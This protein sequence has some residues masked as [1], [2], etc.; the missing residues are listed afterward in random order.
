MGEVKEKTNG[1]LDAFGKVI[2]TISITMSRASSLLLI[3][4]AILVIAD[5]I[6]RWV[7]HSSLYITDIV[8]YMLVC[9]VF[10]SIADGLRGKHHIAADVLTSRMNKR[11]K[12]L[13][14]GLGLL[15]TFI[16]TCIWGYYFTFFVGSSYSSGE[17]TSNFIRA[18]F[19]PAKAI[20]AL[21]V[22][23]FGLMALKN[24]LV[25]MRYVIQN[26]DGV[27]F[28]KGLNNPGIVIPVYV[29]LWVLSVVLMKT[30]S[31][32]AGVVVLLL[33]L[34]CSGAS[35]AISIM[36]TGM[37]VL[38]LL[39][40]TT[41]ANLLANVPS[42][43]FSYV[44][45]YSLLALPMFIFAGAVMAE[46]GLGDAIFNFANV[47]VR[48]IRGGLGI[49][50]VIAC[51]I[52]G[53]L[54]GSSSACCMTIGAVG[55]PALVKNGYD[56]GT[57]A[58]LIAVA[59]GIGIMI[60]P[61]NPLIVYGTLTDSSI[62]KLFMAGIGPGI[63]LTVMLSI[64]LIFMCRKGQTQVME[65]ASLREKAS[66]TKKSF[67]A[68]LLPVIILG[69]IYG[70][71]FTITE[72]AAVAA[73]YAVLYTILSRAIPLKRIWTLIGNS[74][75]T[76]AFIEF[77]LIAAAILQKAVTLMRLPNK[78]LESTGNM[79]G[80]T[81]VILVTVFCLFLG[82]FIDG[83]SI[84]TLVVPLV[85]TSLEQ[86]GYNLYWFGAMMVIYD[87]IGKVTPP[88]GVNLF[89]VQKLGD[90]EATDVFKGAMPFVITAILMMILVILF[91]AIVLW[92]PNHMA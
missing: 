14:M 76:V 90:L 3:V 30:V 17:L 11:M 48:H 54:S 75:H 31:P 67:F 22:I 87:T 19:W 82:M 64:T 59:A 41:T 2:D 24:F 78:V 57:A 36:T 61:S 9:F 50:V 18:P 29:A 77:I 23:V 47:W 46:G 45:K 55:Y 88:V 7:G 1:P 42:M 33:T 12:S 53:A 85:A 25:E 40:S 63:L 10:L 62:G 5:I 8:T 84:M 35:I 52:F 92:L 71:I 60:P 69:G 39:F 49:G 38:G 86:Y 68:L 21:G 89:I 6:L 80:L 13:M 79:N 27:D 20:A 91:P 37:V 4:T 51:A 83:A 15:L 28:G 73:V 65:K 74:V 26:P 32:T 81:F 34:L 16:V 44:N 58:G 70:G 56:K 43:T 66:T 72:A